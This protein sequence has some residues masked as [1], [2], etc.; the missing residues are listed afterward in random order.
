MTISTV[1]FI[2]F[3]PL[4]FHFQ[5]QCTFFGTSGYLHGSYT[6]LLYKMDIIPIFFS[7]L[8]QLVLWISKFSKVT[9]NKNVED[10]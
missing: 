6:K 9:N 1:T 3:L 4:Y 7:H 2:V 10:S 8:N 5:N